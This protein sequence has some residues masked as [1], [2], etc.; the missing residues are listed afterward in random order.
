M[1][2]G[3]DERTRPPGAPVVDSG[4][5]W[6]DFAG[7]ALL[8]AAT[9]NVIG[10]IAAI[11]ESDFFARDASYFFGDL[12]SYG[13]AILIIGAVQA[14]AALGV[15]SKSFPGTWLAVV[16]AGLSAT[17]QLLMLPAHPLW[18]LAILGVDVLIIHALLTHG[19]L[20]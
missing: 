9:A 16:V 6:I 2:Q 1:Q 4:R 12:E 14:I 15:W 11:G 19:E 3:L 13:V 20:D 10:G 17:A 7:I 5:A 18:A 8:I